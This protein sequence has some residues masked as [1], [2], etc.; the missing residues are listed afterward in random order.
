MQGLSICLNDIKICNLKGSNLLLFL[1]VFYSCFPWNNF[2]YWNPLFLLPI[3][4][5]FWLVHRCYIY[6]KELAG[7]RSFA[8]RFLFRFLGQCLS[9]FIQFYTICKSSFIIWYAVKKKFLNF[10]LACKFQG[11]ATLWFVISWEFGY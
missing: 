5:L 3:R 6:Y 4:I 2:C 11:L 1:L 10:T 9:L 7:R 8:T